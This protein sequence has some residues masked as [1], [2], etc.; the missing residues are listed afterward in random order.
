M[1][2]ANRIQK[3]TYLA[4]FLGASSLA[5]KS[6]SRMLSSAA[7]R[8]FVGVGVVTAG[9]ILGIVSGWLAMNG[10]GATNPLWAADRAPSIGNLYDAHR[11]SGQK[12]VN[13]SD[14]TG[15]YSAPQDAISASTQQAVAGGMDQAVGLSVLPLTQLFH[16]SVAASWR[17]SDA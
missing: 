17:V 13:R 6:D 15:I 7:G 2:A 1:S 14:R 10:P 3:R 12:P 9:A 11:H 8:L 5:H 16:P 4:Q